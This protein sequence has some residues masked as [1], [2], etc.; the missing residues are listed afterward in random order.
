MTGHKTKAR[1]WALT[2]G[3]KRKAVSRSPLFLFLC[4]TFCLSAQHNPPPFSLLF[5]NVENLFDT[6]DDPQTEDDNFT[7]EGD[8]HWTNKRLTG[9]LLNISKVIMNASGWEVP[10]IVVFAEIENRKMLEKLIGETP[11][12]SSPY[13]IIHKESPD[14]RGIDVGMIYNHERFFPIEYNYYPLVI[15]SNVVNTRELFYVSGVLKGSDTL[16]IFGNHWPSRYS[17]MLETRDLRKASALL[18]KNKVEEL[19]MKYKFPKIVIVGDFN[20]NPEDE[21]LSKVL[22]AGKVEIPIVD[23]QLYNL[24]FDMKRDNQGSLKYQSRWFVFD[25]VIVSGSLLSA[26]SGVCI[27]P[28]YA[29]ILALPFLLENDKK[30]GGKKPFRTYYGFTYNGGFSDHLPVLLRMDISH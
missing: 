28:E 8:L 30:F 7:P 26:S 25:Q 22:K 17:G 18:L 24:F 13:K 10:D 11:L 12:K 27:K 16:H 19:N 21:T 29:K 14:H 15:N 20:D 6:Q 4:F 23:D 1:I 2:S 5:Y 3:L 9:K